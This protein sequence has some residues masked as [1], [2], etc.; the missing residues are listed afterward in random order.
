MLPLPIGALAVVWS[1]SR[2]TPCFCFCI[3]EALNLDRADVDCGN[4][5]LTIRRTKFYKSRLVPFGPQ[6]GQAL[7]RYALR[8]VVPGPTAPFFTTKYGRRVLKDTFHSTF[9]RV[10][11]QAGIQR[12][13]GGRFQPRVHDL[14]HTFAV[15]RLTSWY[16]QGMDV[17]KLLP[18]LSVYM[19]HVHLAGT[20]VYLSMT[21]ELLTEANA[22]FERYAGKE[23]KHG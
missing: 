10:C 14:R 21:P 9:R 1:R 12:L 7:A 11:R 15:H 6:L 16:R 23:D 8:P 18:Q 2:S 20:Q 19:G 22:R 13:D 17:Q 3:S 5:V 4:A